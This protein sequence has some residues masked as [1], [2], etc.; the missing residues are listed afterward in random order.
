MAAKQP[1]ETQNKEITSLSDALVMTCIG[2]KK[3][4]SRRGYWV[5]TAVD[6][7]S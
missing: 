6:P 5:G 3:S 7:D 2:V 1:A 4:K